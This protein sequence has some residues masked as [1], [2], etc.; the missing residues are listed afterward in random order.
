MITFT[1]LLLIVYINYT[2][3]FLFNFIYLFITVYTPLLNFLSWSSKVLLIASYMCYSDS[4][5]PRTDSKANI[6]KSAWHFMSSASSLYVFR[7]KSTKQGKQNRHNLKADTK[8]KTFTYC[9]CRQPGSISFRSSS[10][11]VY[12]FNKI[13]ISVQKQHH[14]V[15]PYWSKNLLYVNI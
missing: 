9:M 1:L 8:S 5:P 4:S 13:L 15:A 11:H 10:R 6:L 2:I 3:F 7:V 12:T 14:E